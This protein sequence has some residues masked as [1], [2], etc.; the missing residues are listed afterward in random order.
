MELKENEQIV[1]IIILIILIISYSTAT[2]Y[3][4]K[5][6]F[7]KQIGCLYYYY[8]MITD[9]FSNCQIENISLQ[10]IIGGS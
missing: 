5:N 9:N 10:T 1:F 8:P 6:H 7:D 4:N 3:D 2:Y